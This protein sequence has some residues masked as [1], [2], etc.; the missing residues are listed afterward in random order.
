MKRQAS[1]LPCEHH[2]DLFNRCV[3][4]QQQFKFGGRLHRRHC[5]H[6]KTWEIL[7][8]RLDTRYTFCRT[9]LTQLDKRDR[10]S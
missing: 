7:T 4:C 1:E 6:Q 3:H 9:C 2:L 5:L 10:R 8:P